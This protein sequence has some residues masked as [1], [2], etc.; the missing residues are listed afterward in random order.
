MPIP[1]A[2]PD[3]SPRR[4]LRDVV[5]KQLQGA[6]LDGTL[7]PGERLTDDELVAWLGVSRTPIREALLRLRSLGWSTSSEPLHEDRGANDA[8]GD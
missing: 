1:V 4:L 7:E 8:G 3:S 6:I 5:L 2:T